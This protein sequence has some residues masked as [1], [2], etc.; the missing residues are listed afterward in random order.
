MSQLKRMA[1][2]GGGPAGLYAAILMRRKLPQVEVTVFEQ[3]PQGATF[4]FGVVFSD[5]ALGFLK[6][7]DPEIHDLILPHM[8]RW[9]NMTLNLP[10][11]SVT[12]DGVGFTAL[13]RLPRSNIST[14]T[15]PGSARPAPSTR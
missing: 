3:N 2:V 10:E 5:Q 7:A 15:S 8:E 4:G 11:G 9:K 13:G 12:L 14:A 1:I 6:A